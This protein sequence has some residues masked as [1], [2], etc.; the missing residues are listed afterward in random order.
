MKKKKRLRSLKK[1]LL[2]KVPYWLLI[3]LM[4]NSSLLTGFIEYY[5]LKKNLDAQLL[6]LSNT[7]KD[8]KELVQMLK[9]QVLPQKGYLLA[10]TWQDIGKS[11]V[12]SG[13]IDKD[14]YKELF[15]NDSISQKH[16]RYLEGIHK[17]HMEISEGNARFMVNTLWALGLVNKGS[18]LDNG[19]MK[20]NGSD[21]G[22]FAST[23]GWTLGEKPATELYAAE[24]IVPLTAQQEAVVKRISESVFRPCCGNSTYFPDCNH[25]MA[26]LGY[27]ELAVKQGI[28]EKRIYKDLAALNSFWFPQQ[29]VEIAAYFAKQ[30]KSWQQTDPKVLL[31]VQYSSAQG[32]ARVREAIQ[33][34]PGLNS[35]GGCSA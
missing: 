5:I 17:D 27:I 13:A 31:S 10:V 6:L 7:T 15:Q 16:M 21:I 9:Q 30:G 18:V 23:G 34:L 24:K 35:G 20:T 33:S 28:S 14:K 4:L 1:F 29:Y 32:A 2:K 22:N 3:V 11:L 12:A 25:G 19:P 8:P 26:A